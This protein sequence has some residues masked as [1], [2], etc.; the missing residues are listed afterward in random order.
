MK[1]RDSRKN[2]TLNDEANSQVEECRVRSI[3]GRGRFAICLRTVSLSS[4]FSSHYVTHEASPP[5]PTGGGWWHCRNWFD[6]SPAWLRYYTKR[7]TGN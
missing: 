4:M 5:R 2:Y 6:A 3:S 1:E 7:F